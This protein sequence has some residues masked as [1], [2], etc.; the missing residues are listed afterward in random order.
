MTIQ[1][2]DGQP[3][4]ISIFGTEAQSIRTNA[5]GD[6]QVL[7]YDYYEPQTVDNSMN[8]A[9]VIFYHG[10][11]YQSGSANSICAYYHIEEWLQ[12]GFH[13][14]II[15]YRRGWYGDG[16]TAPGGEAPISSDEAQKFVTATDLALHDAQSAWGHYNENTIGHGRYYS[17]FSSNGAGQSSSYYVI[18]GNSAGGSLVARTVYT[19][20]YPANNIRVIGAISGFGT[21]INSENVLSSHSDVP[22]IIVSGLFD[23][24]SPVYDNNIFFSENTPITKGT[25]NFYDDLVD[26]GYA[27]R[28]LISA[29]KG[30]GWGEFGKVVEYPGDQYCQKTIPDF[31]VDVTQNNIGSMISSFALAFFYKR[32]KAISIPN[33]QHFRF[34]QSAKYINGVAYPNID[35]TNDLYEGIG[36][37]AGKI[38]NVLDIDPTLIGLSLLENMKINGFVYGDDLQNGLGYLNVPN[39]FRYEPVQTELENGNKPSF[40]KNKYNI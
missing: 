19:H 29:Q 16:S 2:P 28:I 22:T 30:H 13:G 9:T 10:G 17:Q 4:D 31:A 11:G 6:E 23:D 24:I 3:R 40:V 15:G 37:T 35:D 33:Y 7:F 5:L 32:Y 12:R 25:F 8:S 14:L 27:V 36:T 38:E 1:Q 39:G 20:E 34:T 21:F 26:N 18:I